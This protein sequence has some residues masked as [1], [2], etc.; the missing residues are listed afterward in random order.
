MR[1][2]PRRSG[3]PSAPP[4]TGSVWNEPCV[5]VA[6]KSTDGLRALD[7]PVCFV[8]FRV[9]VDGISPDRSRT[10]C[11]SS[12]SAQAFLQLRPRTT[13]SAPGRRGI[14][15]SVS[16]GPSSC[17]GRADTAGRPRSSRHLASSCLE[18]VQPKPQPSRVLP[19]E[20]SLQRRPVA[21]R[22]RLPNVE[23]A[24]SHWA[25]CNEQYRRTNSCQSVFQDVFW[26]TA[27]KTSASQ[28]RWCPIARSGSASRSVRCSH[29]QES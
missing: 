9:P 1:P 7:I 4:P 18:H 6:A 11:T 13:R 17:P 26:P 2:R 28:T 8:P 23:V 29:D 24:Q 20:W 14:S 21:T 15:G 27:R 12:A 25:P 3:L 16:R 22:P 5:E 19:H 10:R